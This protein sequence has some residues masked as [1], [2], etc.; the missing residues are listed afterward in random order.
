MAHA[1]KSARATLREIAGLMGKSIGYIGD[2]EHGRKRWSL[3]LI[4]FYAA[5]VETVKQQAGGRA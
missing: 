4:N 2:L 3:K 5:A 1:R